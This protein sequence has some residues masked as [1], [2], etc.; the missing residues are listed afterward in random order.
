MSR[1]RNV[2]NNLDDDAL[3]TLREVMIQEQI[4]DRGVASERTIAAMRVVPR[5]VFLPQQMWSNAYDDRP[6]PIGHGQTISQP[7]I[8]SL[9]TSQLDSLPIGC[10]ILE[11]GSGCGYQT[12]ILVEMGFEVHSIEIVPELAQRSKQILEELSLLPASITN[13]D[14]RLGLPEIAPFSGILAAAC[15]EEIPETWLKQQATPGII[16]APVE[17]KRNQHLIRIDNTESDGAIQRVICPV[18]FVKLH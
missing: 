12:A 1:G 9:M 11:I 3:N 13:G 6:H 4:I 15:G 14:G 16:V 7:Y 8:V 10:R 2:S 17:G 18:R 5:H